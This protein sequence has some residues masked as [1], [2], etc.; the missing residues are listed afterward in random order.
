MF[1]RFADYEQRVG[2]KKRE[3]LL[4][5]SNVMTFKMAYRTRIVPF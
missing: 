1:D 2:G 5:D 4:I 3:I